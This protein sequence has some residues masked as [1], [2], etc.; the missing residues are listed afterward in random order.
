MIIRNKKGK[1]IKA[2]VVLI[3]IGVIISTVGF[4]IGGFNL[5]I[6]KSNNTQK[7]YNIINID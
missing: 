3:V 7:W 5:D 1:A 6:F 2:S 4:G